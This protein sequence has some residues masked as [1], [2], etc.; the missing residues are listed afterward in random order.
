MI[1]SNIPPSPAP[2]RGF[3]RFLFWTTLT[4]G[5]LLCL[6]IAFLIAITVPNLRREVAPP[7]ISGPEQVGRNASDPSTSPTSNTL[8]V[9]ASTSGT[10][11][12]LNLDDF[13]H[14]SPTMRKLTQAWLD[15]YAETDKALDSIT[16]PVLRAQALE[17]LKDRTKMRAFLNLPREWGNQ[18]YEEA[19]RKRRDPSYSLYV[20]AHDTFG[21]SYTNAKGYSF[22]FSYAPGKIT[23]EQ[24]Q[25]L[26]K[27]PE[28]AD[29]LA[30]EVFHSDCIDKRMFFELQAHNHL[31]DMAAF[32]SLS[33]DNPF[34]VREGFQE[35]IT[36]DE[37]VHCL[38][39]TGI[40]GSL[41]L[42]GRSYQ[43]TLDSLIVRHPANSFYRYVRKA[44]EVLVVPAIE[45]PAQNQWMKANPWWKPKTKSSHENGG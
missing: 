42:T 28:F 18:S 23:D 30:K 45:R 13:P 11:S 27:C 12:F 3:R 8:S 16:D 40:R 1:E 22:R 31:W 24:K 17:F 7:E 32:L 4:S 37:E 34:A 5:T 21:Y 41:G 38:R 39:Q 29:T 9:S 33:T 2:K 36:W 14:L 35:V 20:Q 26:G 6:F 25:F 44:G 15:Q 10:Q 43:R 19:T